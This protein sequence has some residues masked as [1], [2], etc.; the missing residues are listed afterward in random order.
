VSNANQPRGHYAGQGVSELRTGPAR[1][2]LPGPDKATLLPNPSAAHDALIARFTAAGKQPLRQGFPV[3][4]GRDIKAFSNFITHALRNDLP[5][6][7]AYDAAVIWE[8][9]RLAVA[10]LRDLLRDVRDD[11]DDGESTQY[12]A[13]ALDHRSW[14]IRTSLATALSTP[15]EVADRYCPWKADFFTPDR[16][17]P[18]AS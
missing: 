10:E 9:W 7:D 2:P 5:T 14:D 8:K 17:H 1:V 12:I 13:V 16:L 15:G 18:E 11:T 4:S 3:M 6:I